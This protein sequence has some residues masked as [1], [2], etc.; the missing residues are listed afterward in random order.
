MNMKRVLYIVIFSGL[1]AACSGYQNSTSLGGDDN[2]QPRTLVA[3][4]EIVKLMNGDYFKV[5]QNCGSLARPAFLCTGILL[6]VT[7]PDTSYHSWDPSP[8][9]VKSGGV[10]FSYLRSDARFSVVAFGYLNGIILYPYSF[11]GS[12]KNTNIDVMCFF[13]L[14]GWTDGRADAGC[15]NYSQDL[16]GWSRPCQLQNITTAAGWK[17]HYDLSGANKNIWQCGFITSEQKL[18]HMTATP[19]YEGIKAMATVPAV[20]FAQ[21][22]ELRL[23]TWSTTDAGYPANLPIEAFFYVY[24]QNRVQSRAAIV[25]GLQGA[26]HDQ[27]DYY[28]LT[29]IVV[30]IVRLSLPSTLTTT[31]PIFSYSDSDQVVQSSR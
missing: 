13:P 5:V 24:R 19:F 7:N 21:Q 10:S 29:K 2:S 26:Q 25:K 12:D 31:A 28:N 1:L 4:D 15:G 17:N 6:R 9:S 27:Q 16:I 23:A 20:S 3:G 22:N 30:P 11:A 18:P 8:A 14:D